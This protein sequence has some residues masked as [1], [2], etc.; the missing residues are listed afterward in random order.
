MKYMLHKT[1]MYIFVNSTLGYIL[2]GGDNYVN[3]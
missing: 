3:T 1:K 2:Y